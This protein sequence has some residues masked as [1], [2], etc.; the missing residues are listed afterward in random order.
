MGGGTKYHA[1]FVP[2]DEL[3]SDLYL[4]AEQVLRESG[5]AQ[6]EISNF[7]RPGSKSRHNLKYWTRQPYLGFGVD[8]HSMLLPKAA[9]RDVA[10]IRFATPDSLDRF[11]A[12]E[13]VERTPVFRDGAMEESFFL[14]LR[15]ND[16]VDL[17]RVAA[18][19]G[20]AVVQSLTCGIGDLIHAGLLTRDGM[21]IALTSR[22]RMLS[23]EVFEK[24]L[25]D[26]KRNPGIAFANT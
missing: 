25:T 16:G 5:V 7:A 21:T 26:P 24:F 1:H 14:G 12:G 4:R 22:G 19:F 11:M 23:N 3:T 9:D 2:D 18:E 8:A 15:L 10:A 13:P 17:D 20:A 6:Y